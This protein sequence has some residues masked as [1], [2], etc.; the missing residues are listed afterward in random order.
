LI[1]SLEPKPSRG[2][3]QDDVRTV[4]PDVFVE[5]I[6]GEWVIYLNDDGAAAA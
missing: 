1:A 5:K 4:L 2:F 3:E 6:S